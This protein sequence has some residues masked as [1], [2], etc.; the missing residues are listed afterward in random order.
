ML[1]YGHEN[2]AIEN[3]NRAV[4][5][6]EEMS[7]MAIKYK[8]LAELAY[9]DEIN[10][11]QHS[12]SY[13]MLEATLEKSEKWLSMIKGKY[14]KR[15]RYEEK[16]SFEVLTSHIMSEITGMPIEIT[17][18]SVLQYAGMSHTVKFKCADQEFALFIPHLVGLNKETYG[19][20]HKGKLALSYVEDSNYSLIARSY[21]EEDLKMPFQKY[22]KS[23]QV[24]N[25]YFE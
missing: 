13:W 21:K 16:G 1:D 18:I 11:I 5:L 12:V 23:H 25:E 17:S 22:I 24:H 10:T 9:L 3:I 15:K 2:E 19:Y 8:K 7:E 6:T 4:K 14:D 20:C